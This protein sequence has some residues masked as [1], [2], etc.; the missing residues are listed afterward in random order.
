MYGVSETTIFSSGKESVVIRKYLNGISSGVVLDTTDFAEKFIQCGHVIIRDTTSG[1]YKPM[2]VKD[3]AYEALPANCEYVGVCMTTTP[4]D[5]PH[6]GVITAGEVNDK[7]VPFS[8]ESI[9]A[10]IKT[11]VPTLQWGHD[12]L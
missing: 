7:A 10:A 11:A 12:E 1:E 6:V 2:P 3:G 9:K 4:V 5:T 8:V